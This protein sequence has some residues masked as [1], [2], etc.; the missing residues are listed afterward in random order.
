MSLLSNAIRQVCGPVMLDLGCGHGRSTKFLRDICRSYVVG[1][2]VDF[3]KLRSGRDALSDLGGLDFICADAAYLPLRDS[4]INSVVAVLTLHEVD[5]AAIDRVLEEVRRVLRPNGD[6]L[7]IDKIL[8][9]FE[10]PTEELTVMTEHAYHKALEYVQGIR[11]WGVR[12]VDEVIEKVVSKN[13]RAVS[14]ELVVAGE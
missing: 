7:I 1:V 12:K 8:T 14:H 6:F 5:E 4:S 11:A 9:T 10:S 13:F 2:D 3:E